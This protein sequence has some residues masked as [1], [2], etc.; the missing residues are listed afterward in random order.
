MRERYGWGETYFLRQH[1]DTAYVHLTT[2]FAWSAYEAATARA[3]ALVAQAVEAER[4][5]HTM[6]PHLIAATVNA[7]TAIA[8]EYGQTQQLRARISDVLAPILRGDG[9]PRSIVAAYVNLPPPPAAA[10]REQGAD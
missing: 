2:V 5:R 1:N 4:E 3:A 9:F 7:I 8:A 6:K 10:I